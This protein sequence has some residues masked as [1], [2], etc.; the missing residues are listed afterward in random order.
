MYCIVLLFSDSDIYYK[1]EI[2]TTGVFGPRS[3]HF[4]Q[5]MLRIFLSNTKSKRQ[6]GNY[7][8][9]NIFMDAT[10]YGEEQYCL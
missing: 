8:K 4:V 5:F 10:F 7:A 1:F 9:D 6:H 3:S 2:C